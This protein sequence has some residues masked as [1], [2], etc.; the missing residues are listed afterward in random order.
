MSVLKGSL[1]AGKDMAEGNEANRKLPE[2]ERLLRVIGE[3]AQD[4]ITYSTVDGRCS[5]VS[6]SAYSALG[7]TPQELIAM[8]TDIRELFDIP[9]NLLT[10]SLDGGMLFESRVKHRD[11]TYRWFETTVNRVAAQEGENGAEEMLLSIGRDITERK[12]MEER[13]RD[14][15]R[16]YKS[17]FEYNPS[18]IYAFDSDGGLSSFN[19]QLLDL[20]GYSSEELQAIQFQQLIHEDDRQ[21]AERMLAV[22]MSGHPVRFEARMVRKDGEV[23]A[24]GVTNVP[25]VVDGQVVGAYGIASDIRERKQYIEQI[26]RLS[27]RHSLILGSISEGLYML[28]QEG[29]AIFLNPAAERMLGYGLEEFIG[30]CSH[31]VIHHTRADGTPYTR[32][33]NP[34]TRTIADGLARSMND[35]VFWRKDGTSFLVEYRVN[36][37]IDDGRIVGAVVVFNDVTGEREIRAAKENAERADRAKSEFLAMMSHEIRTPMNGILGMTDLLLETDL[38]EEQQEYAEIIH[39]SGETLLR[40]LNDILDFSKIEAGKLVLEDELFD[41]P[42]TIAMTIDLFKPRAEQKGLDLVCTVA[43][44]VPGAVVGDATRFRQVL[45]NLVGN[46]I[47]F[48]ESGSVNVSVDVRQGAQGAGDKESKLLRITVEDTGIGIPADK[49]KHLFQSF[50]QL[51]PALSRTYGGTGLGL[52]ITKRLVELMGGVIAVDSIEGEGSTFRFEMELHGEL[53]ASVGDQGSE[54]GLP[55]NRARAV[56][57]PLPHARNT[58]QAQ[59]D[60]GGLRILLAEDHPV[61]QQLFLRVLDRLGY[62]ADVVQNGVEAVEAILKQPYNL[63]FMD[64]QMP[65]MDG[66]KATGLIRQLL[67]EN[68]LPVIVALTAHARREDRDMCLSAGMDD[69]ISKPIQ[70]DEV[71]RVF[72]RWRHGKGKAHS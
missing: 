33:S 65:V 11:G 10:G 19:L 61:N 38:T 29:R 70:M 25:I 9:P 15:E 64:I 55:M 68:K 69:Y 17:L 6:Q 7:Y 50:S 32:E 49:L 46:A 30:R 52:A 35:E 14:S 5:Y 43:P 57:Q 51:H 20:T 66:I 26:E 58:E 56:W 60:A 22:T 41:L 45:T 21:Q 2:S 23:I 67:P 8:G 63:V 62:T 39:S 12:Q 13:L 34:I 4:V 36:P 18:S 27:Y 31:D 3:Y 40:I 42:G 28:D 48:T 1:P 71:C 44:D 72:D 37:I 54:A 47:K 59:A 16:R 24:C 53:C